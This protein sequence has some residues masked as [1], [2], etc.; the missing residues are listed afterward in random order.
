M[1]LFAD[2]EAIE[3]S[4][5][6]GGERT[7][8]VGGCSYSLMKKRL[9]RDPRVTFYGS[10]HAHGCSYSLMKKRLRRA[11]QSTDLFP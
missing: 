11:I 3:T 7:T 10:A 1:Q 6:V 8:N 9:R 4:C 2:E 5:G